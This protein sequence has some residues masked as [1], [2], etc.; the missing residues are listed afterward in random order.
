MFNVNK[1]VSVLSGEDQSG[2][3]QVYWFRAFVDENHA[4]SLSEL[5]EI[6]IRAFSLQ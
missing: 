4:A 6:I 1:V 3:L 2:V 5:N